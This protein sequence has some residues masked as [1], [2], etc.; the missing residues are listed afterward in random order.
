MNTDNAYTHSLKVGG[1][2]YLVT[3]VYLPTVITN[4]VEEQCNPHCCFDRVLQET[5]NCEGEHSQIVGHIG[6]NHFPDP[7]TIYLR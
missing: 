1:T 2:V 5:G 3:K 7:I 4:T 6:G